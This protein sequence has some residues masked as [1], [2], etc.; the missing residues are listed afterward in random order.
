MTEDCLRKWGVDTFQSTLPRREW[1]QEY[2]SLPGK[3]QFQST[4]PRREWQYQLYLYEILNEFQS[5]LP[6]REWLPDFAITGY[7]PDIS[8]HTPAKGV[9]LLSR[10]LKTWRVNFNPHSREGSDRPVVDFFAPYSI[11]IHTPAKGVTG[12]LRTLIQRHPN[13]NPHS[14]EGSDW[15]WAWCRTWNTISIHTPAKGVTQVSQ[16]RCWCSEFQSTL[17]RREWRFC[18]RGK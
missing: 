1:R 6:R 15:A 7:F 2:H 18:S 14:R 12:I 10:R 16:R 9:T 8:I 4:L 13:F 3:L 11:S 5:T 17:P